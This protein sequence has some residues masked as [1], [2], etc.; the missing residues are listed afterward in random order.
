MVAKP[1][2]RMIE[3]FKG[4]SSLVDKECHTTMLPNDMDISRLMIYAQQIEESNIME[5]RKEGRRP[6][7]DDYSDQRPMN[8][9]YNQD[10]SIGN[11]DKA[12][13]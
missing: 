12:P 10:F 13:N 8:R 3:F 9:F 6:R 5:I 7:F 11:K 2:D 1:R 4:V